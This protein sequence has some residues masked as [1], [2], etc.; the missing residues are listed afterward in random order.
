[1]V[2]V[3]S[4]CP[5]STSA[6]LPFCV[7]M[8]FQISHAVVTQV[9]DEQVHAVAGN[10]N[11]IEHGALGGGESVAVSPLATAI[12]ATAL[13]VVKFVAPAPRRPADCSWWGWNSRSGRGCSA[14]RPRTACRSGSTRPAAPKTGGRGDDRLDRVE[15]RLAQHHVRGLSVGAGD[16]LP[17]QHAIVLRIGDRQN[18]PVRGDCRGLRMPVCVV[19]KLVRQK[20]RLAQHQRGLPDAHRTGAAIGWD[21]RHCGRQSLGDVLEHQHAV[22][23]GRKPDPV[24][25]GD[26]QRIPSEGEPPAPP[27]SVSEAP[28]FWEVNEVCPNTNRAACPVT[29]SLGKRRTGT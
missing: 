7:G 16:R 19:W 11:R 4:G 22:V 15:I 13:T 10:R 12:G 29:N 27:S 25:I 5:I 20:V 23:D 1:M 18:V 6:G 14:C 9:R 26:E 17:Q 24:G 2:F 8:E 28:K 3:K 21:L